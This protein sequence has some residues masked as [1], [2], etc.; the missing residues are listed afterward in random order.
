METPWTSKEN[1]FTMFA[2]VDVLIKLFYNSLDTQF[3]IC[4]CPLSWILAAWYIDHVAP[5]ILPVSVIEVQGTLTVLKMSGFYVTLSNM[6]EVSFNCLYRA[7]SEK[8]LTQNVIKHFEFWFI[9]FIVFNATFSNILAIS[10]RPVLWWR[11]PEYPRR[12]T[13]HGQA[14]GKLYHLRLRVECTFYCNLQ[15]R[16]RTHAVL[17]IGLYELLGNPTT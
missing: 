14:I 6:K 16:A 11:K 9:W 7:I 12:T 15:S 13:D 1:L 8:K 4:F 2:L 17:V 10:W 5:T 3:A